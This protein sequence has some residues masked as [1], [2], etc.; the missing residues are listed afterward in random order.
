MRGSTITEETHG[1]VSTLEFERFFEVERRRLFRA[2]YLMTGSAHE[3][4]E[5]AQDAF[6]KIWERWDRVGG[7]DDPVG[8]LYRTAMN[9]ARSRARRLVRA[10]RAP[11]SAER[12]VE[13]YGAADTHDAVVRALARL[14]PRQRQAV[15]LVE[16]LDRSTQEAADLMHV[17]NST[18]RSLTSEA[19]KSMRAAMEIDDE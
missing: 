5:L 10:A 19:R 13:P 2:L 15:V 4:E 3:A 18:V 16:L 11:F 14:A 9:L 7:M 12:L 6:L 8:Y 1:A 17:S